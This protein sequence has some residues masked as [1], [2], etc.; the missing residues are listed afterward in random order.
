MSALWQG[1]AGLAAALVFYLVIPIVAAYHVRSS[2]RRFRTEV[3]HAPALPDVA[4]IS[5][6]DDAG[7]TRARCIGRLEAVQ[8]N[9]RIWLGTGGRS[10]AVNLH[11]VPIYLLSV[12]S[13]RSQSGDRGEPPRIVYWNEV[14]ALAEGTRFLVAGP[15]ASRGGAIEFCENGREAPLVI[16]YDGADSFVV[17]RATWT[18]RQRNEYWNQLTPFALMSGALAQILLAA[19]VIGASRATALVNLVLGLLPFLPVVPPGVLGYYFYRRLW[20]DARRDRAIRDLLALPTVANDYAASHEYRLPF[21]EL[22][23]QGCD[24]AALVPV[25]NGLTGDRDDVCWGPAD[26][27]DRM[28]PHLASVRADSTDFARISRRAWRRELA[29][30]GSLGLGLALNTILIAVVVAWVLS[31][32]G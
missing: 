32:P 6:S 10:V 2:W 9:D 13:V 21:V 26:P 14:S 7:V 29:A 19:I 22:G 4:E 23:A 16:I 24:G 31:W 1:W 20:R 8:G 25:P 15:A 28:V 3:M 12:R 18:G 11:E 30:L 17:E 5:V 27:D